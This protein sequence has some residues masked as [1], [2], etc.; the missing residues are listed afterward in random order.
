MIQVQ[1]PAQASATPSQVDTVFVEL[2]D[3]QLAVVCGGVAVPSVVG[4]PSLPRSRRRLVGRKVTEARHCP[5]PRFG[6]WSRLDERRR[7]DEARGASSK[8]RPCRPSG[9]VD[10]PDSLRLRSGAR[11]ARS[12]QRATLTMP[13]APSVPALAGVAMNVLGIETSCD[14]TGVALVEADGD[15]TPRLLAQALHSQVDMH[16]TTAASFPSSPR[17]TTSGA[18][19]R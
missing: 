4:G 17:A 9:V 7:A 19:C 5:R 13:A 3:E 15:A 16:A 11:D 2:D 1:S 10:A 14:E 18:S 8:R 12:A 6:L